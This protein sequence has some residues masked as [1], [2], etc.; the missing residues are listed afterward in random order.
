MPVYDSERAPGTATSDQCR[1][2]DLDGVPPGTASG[3]VCTA[4]MAG[5]PPGA[6]RTRQ[7][8]M[9]A[10]AMWAGKSSRGLNCEDQRG[11]FRN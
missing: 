1:Q 10:T 6:D 7:A 11:T 4:H 8:A 2:L 3:R 5:A 9:G